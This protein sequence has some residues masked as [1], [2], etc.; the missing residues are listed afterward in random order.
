MKHIPYQLPDDC[1]K[2]RIVEIEYIDAITKWTIANIEQG[3]DIWFNFN[4]YSSWVIVPD[5]LLDEFLS[6]YGQYVSAN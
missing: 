2:Y 5:S 3:A 6:L 1:I 4:S